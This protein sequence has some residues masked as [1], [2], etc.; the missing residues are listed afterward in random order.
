MQILKEELQ[1]LREQP[2]MGRQD[3]T[4]GGLR[5]D[6]FAGNGF[7]SLYK[8]SSLD[9]IAGGGMSYSARQNGGAAP[10][11][12]RSV[13]RGTHG[14]PSSDSES[15]GGVLHQR[16]HSIVNNVL[17]SPVLSPFYRKNGQIDSLCEEELENLVDPP[18]DSRNSY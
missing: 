5:S 15:L 8:N 10:M 11:G 17:S 14:Q 2:G 12:G 1:Q 6:S 7:S 13:S 9:W 3:S 16:K 18:R 4:F